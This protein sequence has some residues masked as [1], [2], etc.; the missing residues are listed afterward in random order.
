M[1]V[2]QKIKGDLFGILA[3]VAE[4]EG[5]TESL[6]EG[7]ARLPC[8]RRVHAAPVPSRP[9]GGG[10]TL[11]NHGG[12]IAGFQALKFAG[13]S[14]ALCAD[15]VQQVIQCFPLNRNPVFKPGNRNVTRRQRSHRHL[16]GVSR[17]GV[18][19][20]LSAIADN[21]QVHL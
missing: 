17:K 10:G 21:P 13:E 16:D 4:D 7:N 9:Q 14:F 11:D 12:G 18:G 6:H 3:T 5:D 19:L 8:A 2:A 1:E 20:L 15:T